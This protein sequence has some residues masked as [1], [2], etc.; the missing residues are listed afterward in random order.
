MIEQPN[1]DPTTKVTLGEVYRAVLRVEKALDRH[2]EGH[3][4]NARWQVTTLIAVGGLVLA[5]IKLS[6]GVG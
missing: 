5:L 4:T 3:D 2:E 6:A 1:G